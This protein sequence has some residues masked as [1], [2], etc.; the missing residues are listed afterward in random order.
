MVSL[1]GFW[2]FNVF[3]FSTTVIFAVSNIVTRG[4]NVLRVQSQRLYCMLRSID[5]KKLVSVF[6]FAEVCFH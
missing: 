2:K 5:V 3:S 4:G 6:Q 1:V